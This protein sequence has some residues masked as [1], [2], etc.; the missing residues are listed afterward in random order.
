MEAGELVR[1]EVTL[2]LMR[3]A[4]RSSGSSRFLIDGFPRSLDQ[5]FE[6]EKRVGA[7]ASVLFFDCPQDVMEQRLLARG[8]TSGRVDD[9]PASIRKRFRTFRE[10]S[11]PVIDFYAKQGKVHRISAIP[12]PD[13]VFQ[14][15]QA[16]FTPVVVSVAGPPGAGKTPLLREAADFWGYTYLSVD[17]LVAAELARGSPDAVFIQDLLRHKQALPLELQLR[18]FKRAMARAGSA[19]FL[20]DGFP[21][22][23]AQAFDFERKVAPLS[24]FVQLD[25]SEDELL[26]R[27]SRPPAW[28]RQMRHYLQ[29]T[30]GEL[31][32][33]YD[34]C[35]MVRR[36]DGSDASAVAARL[37]AALQ[38]RIVVVQGPPA[39]GKSTLTGLL[40]DSL[41][42]TRLDPAELLRAEIVRGSDT[43]RLI[44][45]TLAAGRKVPLDITVAVLKAAARSAP[46][47]RLL[48][49]GFPR[50]LQQL[51]AFQAALGEPEFVLQ[52]AAHGSEDEGTVP[53]AARAAYEEETLPVLHHY[54]RLGKLRRLGGDGATAG[55]LAMQ[56]RHFFD[57]EVVF[58]LGGPGAG[59][60][61]QCAR[62]RDEFG[63]RHL[64]AGDLLRAEVARG[65]PDGEMIYSMIKEGKIVPMRVPLRLLKR[66]MAASGSSRFLIDGFPRA[67]DQGLAFEESIAE[68]KFV[69][70]FELTEEEMRR[71]LLNRGKTSGRADDNEAAI[72]KRFRTFQMTSMP[73]V[74]HFGDMGRLRTIS[75]LPPPDEVYAS[76]RRLFQPQL[77][78]LAGASGSGR[79]RLATRLGADKGYCLIRPTD[80]LKAAVAADTLEGRAIAAAFRAGQTAP[81]DLT[82]RII[83]RE[84]LRLGGHKFVLDGYPRRVSRG[85]PAVHDQVFA[86]EEALGVPQLLIWLNTTLDARLK[87]HPDR[88]RMEIAQ[89]KYEREKLPVVQWM[90]ASGRPIAEVDGDADADAVY[91]AVCLSLE[92]HG[93]TE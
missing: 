52:L 83:R 73:V 71:R 24:F 68:A 46:S 87:R 82:L 3:K 43:G 11:M 76:V 55:E 41:S 39:A 61:T 4:M 49:D 19:K 89:D 15:T 21:Q 67:M 50:T 22:S 54:A 77:V 32:S 66:S 14:A 35:G 17:S 72:K 81:V 60:G 64:S 18:L 51:K 90:Q 62:I 40:A 25:V 69:L 47:E 38:P 5:A 74:K 79:R 30:A 27:A 23:K 86:L 36:V 53:A 13:E 10:T 88:T 80:L 9:N 1:V 16:A 2:A 20:L 12:S 63:F 26:A 92:E 31:L 78:L 59:K 85:F 58:V 70:F 28:R 44:E 65:S 37:N 48:I 33:F 6:F 29:H 91:S 8:K 93:V 84:M 34:K 75:S 56:A 45:S 42:W 7:P 57:P